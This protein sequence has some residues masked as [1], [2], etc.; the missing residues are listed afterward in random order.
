ME[1]MIKVCVMMI[2]LGIVMGMYGVWEIVK[3]KR[4][5][6]ELKFSSLALLLGFVIAYMFFI[7]SKYV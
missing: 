2:I 4:N 3:S 7:M 6:K 5:K 1:I